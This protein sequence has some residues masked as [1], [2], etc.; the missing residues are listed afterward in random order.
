MSACG[1]GMKD[2]CV[3]VSAHHIACAEDL[4]GRQEGT[5]AHK[6]AGRLGTSSQN[7]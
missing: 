3:H 4:S 5:L 6:V 1:C 2:S 7:S